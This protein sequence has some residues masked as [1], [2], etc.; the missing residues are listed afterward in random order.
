MLAV[1]GV[2]I[3]KRSDR[4]GFLRFFRCNSEL[5]SGLLILCKP[6]KIVLLMIRCCDLLDKKLKLSMRYF[7]FPHPLGIL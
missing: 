6:G 1:S 2:L 7:T 5:Q 4:R 3:Q